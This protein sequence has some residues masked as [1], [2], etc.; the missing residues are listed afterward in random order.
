MIEREQ[1]SQ[2]ASDVLHYLQDIDFPADRDTVIR[3]ARRRDATEELLQRLDRIPNRDYGSLAD[4]M[5]GL[6]QQH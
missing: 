1:R 5:K 4:V 6:G 2:E 3:H